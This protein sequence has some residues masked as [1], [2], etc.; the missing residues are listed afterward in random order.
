[1]KAGGGGTPSIL[2]QEL[3]IQIQDFCNKHKIQVLY[4]H[5]PGVTNITADRLSKKTIPLYKAALPTEYFK[6][7]NGNGDH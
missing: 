4:R 3:A 7:F 2:L 1:M 6:Q 5:I